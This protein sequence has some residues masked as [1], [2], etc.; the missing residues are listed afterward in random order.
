MRKDVLALVVGWT[1]VILSVPLFI[2]FISPFILNE[3]VMAIRAFTIPLLISI[4]S[5]YLLIKY[6]H[7]E[8]AADRLRDRE[9]FAAVAL[10]WPVVVFIGALPFWLGGMF[11]GPI[12]FYLGESNFKEV[13]GGS[14]RSWFESMSGFTTTGATVI[15]GDTS[16]NCQPVVP[17]CINAQS[18]SLLL[19]RSMTQWL[20][21]M[22]IIML[23]MLILSRYL[24]GGMSI[25][26]AELTGPALS[27]LRP[28]LQETAKILW[29]IYTIMTI[30]EMLLLRFL[31][32]LSWFDSL[33]HA[34]TTMPSGGYSTYDAGIMHFQS[35]SVEWIIIFFMV[36]TGI[37]F[38]L[39]HFIWLKEWFNVVT[40]NELQVYLAV[41]F[42]AWAVMTANLI[43]AADV[44][45]SDSFR[46]AAFQAA[47]IGTSTG[48]A[49][50]DFASWPILSKVILLLL[51][52]VGACAGSTSGGL[53]ILRLRI[54][55]QLARREISRISSP[56]KVHL[57]R[58]DGEVVT[59]DKLWVIVG[60]LSWW[61][62]IAMSGLLMLSFIEYDLDFESIIGIVVSS[63]GNTGP[64]IG[65]FGPTQ[66]WSSL[67]W[68]SMIIT[69]V[70]MWLGRLELLTVIV[71]LSPR[72]WKN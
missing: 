8:D 54:A 17:D 59:D 57:V 29:S 40:N 6:G 13:I 68:S 19:W 12:E 53:K 71:L 63:L 69:S 11:H 5:G 14:I 48:Y 44:S 72:V 42:G 56:R 46:L 51:M 26:R 33:N 1:L 52:I 27:R 60:M 32:G 50:A 61:A 20:G 65:A 49:T 66:T 37:N 55:F 41:L 31:G 10:G 3:P 39:Y 30:T 25:A 4:I 7:S 2:A 36:A 18:R 43:I 23:G 47:S 16:P 64:T 21:G 45:S 67:H 9:A 35:P 58:M 62:V 28:R 15:D 38:T 70:M 24:G 34:L 22:G